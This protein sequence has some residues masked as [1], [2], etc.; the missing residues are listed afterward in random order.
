MSQDIPFSLLSYTL[1]V[2][3]QIHK[4]KN[5]Q[6][7]I[8][9]V[10]GKRSQVYALAL[11]SHQTREPHIF[12]PN[13]NCSTFPHYSLLLV[14]LHAF[15]DDLQFYFLPHL[16]CCE[17]VH[18]PPEVANIALKVGLQAGRAG[19]DTQPQRLP[20]CLQHMVL[21]LQEP[22]LEPVNPRAQPQGT[23]TVSLGLA[24]M[25]SNSN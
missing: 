5:K 17:S 3:P 21:L 16:F 6:K 11:L 20:P 4:K 24:R 10:P 8:P 18:L 2:H 13:T 25:T 23:A 7:K 12:W 15:L 22:H 1:N 9:Q 19:A 14:F